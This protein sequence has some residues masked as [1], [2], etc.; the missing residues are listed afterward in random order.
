MTFPVNGANT[1]VVALD[2]TRTD[3]LPFDL[4]RVAAGDQIGLGD[5]GTDVLVAQ[6]SL[7]DAGHDPGPVDGIY[8]PLTQSATRSFQQARI[9]SLQE[10]RDN[11]PP[12]ARTELNNRIS[13]L[14][15]EMNSGVVGAA[16][17]QQLDQIERDQAITA[18][19]DSIG[20]GD[21][22]GQV[23][24]AQ[25]QLEQE[26]YDPGP[27][28]GIY[29]PLTQAAVQEFQR[30]RLD[31]LEQSRA[32]APPA[33]RSE[34]NSRIT[35]LKAEFSKGIFGDATQAQLDQ[36][37][38]DEKIHNEAEKSSEDVAK[39]TQPKA[40]ADNLDVP[41]GDKSERL[42]EA[43]RDR[44]ID[45]VLAEGLNSAGDSVSVSLTG[46]AKIP[47]GL[48]GVEGEITANVVKTEDDYEVSI[49]GEAALQ[50]GIGIDNDDANVEA[51]LGAGGQVTFTYDSLEA[52]T[53]GVQDLVITGGKHQAFV[54]IVQTASDFK[55]GVESVFGSIDDVVTNGLQSAVDEIPDFV[56]DR[57]PDSI[58]NRLDR[59]PELQ[60]Q[61]LNGAYGAVEE[62]SD[63]ITDIRDFEI[64][65]DGVDI[66][67]G[68]FE[69]RVGG[70][71]IT[72]FDGLLNGIGDQ[73]QTVRDLGQQLDDFSSEQSDALDRLND[74]QNSIEITLE[75][76][77]AAELG[78]PLPVD[79]EG[80]ELGASARAA[81]EVTVQIN[82]DRSA[83]IELGLSRAA[84]L[85]G[86]VG[87][88]GSVSVGGDITYS[89]DFEYNGGFNFETTGEAQVAFTAD[90]E[91]LAKLGAGVP[92]QAGVGGELTFST[93]A[94]EL[95]D[96]LGQISSAFLDGDLE[97]AFE[98]LG[99]VEGDLEI[100]GHAI[101]GVSFKAGGGAIGGGVTV[102]GEV[103]YED[104]GEAL[105]VEDLT[106][107]EAFDF[108]NDQVAV[109]V[110]DLE[111]SLS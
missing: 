106:L 43:V 49:S 44:D 90:A 1:R 5:R 24:D 86:G 59:L 50:L 6:Q 109:A 93:S 13:G 75:L 28:D 29:G 88:S 57:L 64:S 42:I 23:L 70:F 61:I 103:R 76:K 62:L 39:D 72:P 110:D 85:D 71:K 111:A 51:A 37:E 65:H 97:G 107:A 102:A 53:Q 91:A 22:G 95:K 34:L 21:R 108:L 8:G 87:I 12:A 16:T 66:L 99:E 84:G 82:R 100:N 32:D 78:I 17:Q 30:D 55:N 73:L 79:V 63:L 52:A 26:G 3:F 92:L 47:T 14:Q 2:R 27:L 11:A 38:R 60:D 74:A 9:E 4:S 19:I 7:K 10:S 46:E 101:G 36:L 77:A 56:Q 67:P 18:G 54:D 25:Q 105:E 68:R 45:A 104:H 96:D 31:S 58:Q 33:A 80:L 20:V 94:R 35:E 48:F 69:Q 41:A 81:A 98:A 40:P 89:Q 15:E 83:N